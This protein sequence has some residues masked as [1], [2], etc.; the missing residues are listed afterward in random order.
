MILNSGVGSRLGELTKDKPK[1]LL[2]V[3][4]KPLLGNQI[5]CLLSFGIDHCIITTGPFE[6]K[7]K[8]YIKEN[9]PSLNITYVKNPKYQ[10][11]NYIYAMF[12]AKKEVNDDIILL[13][14]DL[15]FTKQ[16]LE[17]LLNDKHSNCV[18]VNK[19]SPLPKKDFKAVLKDERVVKIGVEFFGK[20]A[21]FSMPFYKFS[22]A[23]FIFWLSE[24]EKHIES[25]DTKIYAENVFNEISD[26]ILLYP[27]F[28]QSEICMEIDTEEDLERAEFGDKTNSNPA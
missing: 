11:T 28:F 5:D 13:H 14:G 2:E 16:V 8:K 4:G 18:L 20:E 15:F 6:E 25:G 21:F 9:Y 10:S 17:K 19:D 27:T 7:I 24:I 3:R 23:D 22:K 1:A 12:L 26:R